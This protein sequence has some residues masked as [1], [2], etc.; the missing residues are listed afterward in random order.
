MIHG[1]PALLMAVSNVWKLYPGDIVFT[2]TPAGVGP[3]QIGDTIEVSGEKI[4][5]FSWNIIE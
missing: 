1:I 3:L 2:G 4:G 5:A